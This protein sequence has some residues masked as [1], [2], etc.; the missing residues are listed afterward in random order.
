M[1][2][3]LKFVT[4]CPIDTYFTWQIHLWLES[5][6]QLNLSSK[7]VV[8]LFVP[9]GRKNDKWNQVI[10]LYPEVSF[11]YYIDDGTVG[12][13]LGSYIPILRPY[14]MVKYCEEHPESKDQAI[15]YCDCDILF[16][17]SFNIDHLIDDDVCYLSDTNSYI[18]ASYFDS[19]LKDVL[20]EMLE[21]YK[22]IDILDTAARMVGINR[23]IC[24]KNNM[25]SGGTQYL[26][27]NMDASLWRVMFEKCIPVK[28]YLMDINTKYFGSENKGFQSWCCDM[29]VILWELWRSEHIV[30]VVKEMEFGWSPDNITRLDSVGIY[31]NAGIVGEIQDNYP[32]FYK[33]KY[34]QGNDP[35][36]DTQID[37]VLNHEESKKHCTWYY[38]NALKNLHNKYQLEY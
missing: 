2:R 12:P 37:I 5:L 31:H 1:K 34:H 15:F 14:C 22:T 30:K 18:N 26:L 24:E 38:A 10:D 29:F 33:G 7:A 17:K 11:I 4:V 9:Q 8:L 21:E 19:K 25:H 35:F 3:E 27:K 23:E 36:K 20:P 13:L 6:R 32:C 16:T 28:K